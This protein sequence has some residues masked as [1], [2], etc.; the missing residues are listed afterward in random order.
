LDISVGDGLV[1]IQNLILITIFNT[2]LFLIEKYI[3]RQFIPS[4]IAQTILELPE[5]VYVVR[6][7]PLVIIR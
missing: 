4:W 3:V 2:S 7:L 6:E 1:S 5:E